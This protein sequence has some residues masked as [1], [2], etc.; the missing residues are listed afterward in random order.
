MLQGI[1]PELVEYSKHIITNHAIILI[2]N[3]LRTL[4]DDKSKKFSVE[5]LEVFVFLDIC[6]SDIRVLNTLVY[7]QS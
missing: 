6:M 3:Y 4:S 5:V 1:I 2:N 7:L